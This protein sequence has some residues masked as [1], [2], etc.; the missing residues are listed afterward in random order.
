MPCYHPLKGFIIGINPDTNNNMLKVTS[1]KVDHL[2]QKSDGKFYTVENSDIKYSFN[3]FRDYVDIPCGR[4]IGCRLS[5][6]KQWSDRAALELQY[7]NSNL[8]L[9]L[10]YSDDFVP[11]N[12]VYDKETGEFKY[13]SLTLRKKDLQ[14][15]WKRLR[16][17]CDKKG[18]KI[19]YLAC[20]EYG[21]TTFRL[22]SSLSR[23]CFRI[24]YTGLKIIL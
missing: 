11:T 24:R 7:H 17:Y 15:F 2:E 4:C 6:A 3:V 1:Y 9:T 12:E 20:G 21:S 18:E 8:F 14:D 23:D 22:S 10:T 19:R 13:N 5:H 16:K